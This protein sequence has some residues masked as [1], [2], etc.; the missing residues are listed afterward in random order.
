MR[1]AF[2]H[3]AGDIKAL[4]FVTLPNASPPDATAA[5]ATL[6]TLTFN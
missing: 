4:L 1:Y 5:E 3:T 6:T 2:N